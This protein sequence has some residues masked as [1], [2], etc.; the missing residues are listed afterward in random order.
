MGKSLIRIIPDKEKAKSILSV[1]RRRKTI[2]EVISKLKVIAA[3][4]LQA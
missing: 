3:D 2:E 1:E 4:M